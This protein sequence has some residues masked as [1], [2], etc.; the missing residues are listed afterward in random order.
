MKRK[1][2]ILGLGA[3]VLLVGTAFA[4]QWRTGVRLEAETARRRAEA[5]EAMRLR[6]RNRQLAPQ[7]VS[8]V[9]LANLRADHAEALRLR[10]EMDRL[11][12]QLAE[13]PPEPLPAEAPPVPVADGLDR[14]PIPANEWRNL[15]NGT[16]QSTLQTALWAAASGN[17]GA[18]AETLALD[19]AARLKAQALLAAQPDQI[20]AQYSTTERFVAFLTTRDVPLTSLQVSGALVRENDAQ[21]VVN[22]PTSEQTNHLV[23]LT[24]SRRPDGWRLNVPAAAVDRY[25]RQAGIEA[26]RSAAASP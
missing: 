23:S 1:Q 8:E 9:E 26:G 5:A 7:Q 3:L 21:L 20:R 24:L 10:E 14:A 25:A 18:L 11:T 13:S 6:D 22:L 15:G 2:L 19:E 17:L 16:P 4:W 12:R